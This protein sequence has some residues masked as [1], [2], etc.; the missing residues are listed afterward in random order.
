MPRP[1]LSQ[2]DRIKRSA[3]RLL[4]DLRKDVQAKEAELRRLKD[5]ESKLGALVGPA[6]VR[7]MRGRARRGGRINWRALLANLPEQFKASDVRSM[8][9]LKNRRASEIFAGITRWMDAGLVKRKSRG[10]YAR[11]KQ[12]E[13][14]K[15]KRAA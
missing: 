6:T 9:G 1:L 15:S 13:K 5:E 7:A 14:A 10:V 8:R 3:Q 12:A 4:I 11:V 2:L